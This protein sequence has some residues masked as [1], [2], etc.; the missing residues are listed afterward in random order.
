MYQPQVP[1]MQMSPA[2]RTARLAEVELG[3]LVLL[4]DEAGVGVRADALSARGDL[5][6]G[7]LRLS[8]GAVRFERRRLEEAV[9]AIDIEYELQADLTAVLA[10]A[11]EPGD[12]IVA[13]NR[14]TAG[15]FVANLWGGGNGLLDVASAL[16]RPY[17]AT[18]AAP[19]TVLAWKL[20]ERSERSRVLLV[21]EAA[22]PMSRELPRRAYGEDCD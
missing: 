9:I 2:F 8:G 20:I 7:V 6:E 21:H 12:L 14:P 10:R 22:E 18:R 15:L 1:L 3:C 17:L 13:P 5:S 11:P 16:I 4:H 19:Q